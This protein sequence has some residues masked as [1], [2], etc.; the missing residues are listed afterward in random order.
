M[1]SV[2]ILPAF[3]VALIVSSNVLAAETKLICNDQNSHAVYELKLSEDLRSTTL[4]ALLADSS[5]LSAGTKKLSYEEGESTESVATFGGKTN[6]GLAI[7]LL[8]NAEKASKLS[9]N[10]IL[11]VNVFHQQHKTDILSGHTQFL[12]SKN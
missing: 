2:T 11:E 6:N 3:I 12:C 1:K 4:A 5:V 10:E 7:A 9:P 8:F